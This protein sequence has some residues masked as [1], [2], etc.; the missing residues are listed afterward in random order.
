M[1]S[2]IAEEK[3]KHYMMKAAYGQIAKRYQ[4]SFDGP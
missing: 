3:I 4:S 2:T 1:R